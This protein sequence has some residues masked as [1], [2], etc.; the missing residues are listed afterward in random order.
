MMPFV[1]VLRQL[2]SHIASTVPDSVFLFRLLEVCSLYFC[3]LRCG[4]YVQ[5]YLYI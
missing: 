1:I 4:M 3:L 5:T 2:D